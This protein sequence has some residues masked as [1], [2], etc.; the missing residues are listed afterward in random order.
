MGRE[1]VFASLDCK[2]GN[3]R[4]EATDI[5]RPIAAVAGA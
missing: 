3:G 1:G 2:L 5:E 4:D